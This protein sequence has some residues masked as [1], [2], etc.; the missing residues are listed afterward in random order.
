MQTTLLGLAIAIILA[1]LAALIGPYFVDW[2]QF[3]PQFEAEASRLVGAPVHVRDSLDARLLPTPTLRLRTVTIGVPSDPARLRADRLDVEF[4]LGSLMR[5]EWRAAELALDGLVVDLALDANGRLQ[6]PGGRSAPD[7]G[8]LSVDR[9]RLNGRLALHDAV[10]RDILALD[11][12]NF[13]GDVRVATAAAR[14]DGEFRLGDARYPYRLVTGRAA[15]GAGTRVHVTV[16]PGTRPI[17]F[18]LDGVL[19]F[20]ALV[21]RFDGSASLSRAITLRAGSEH[22][23]GVSMP[24]KLSGKLKADPRAIKLEQL[25]ALYGTEEAGLKLAGSADI[26]L[27]LSPSLRVAL[28]ARQLDADRLL[29][30]ET[31][32]SEPTRL[33]PGL[34][35]FIAATPVPPLPARISLAA[36]GV[37]LGGK[38]AQNLAVD[39]HSDADAWVLDRFEGRLPGAAQVTLAGR[40][41]PRP[42]PHFAGSL[43]VEAAEPDQLWAWMRGSGDAPPRLQKPLRITGLLSA[44][45]ERVALDD[46]DANI[47]GAA[48]TGRFAVSNPASP[49]HPDALRLE[50]AISGEKL[51]LDG[52]LALGRGIAGPRDNWP[53]EADLALDLRH[54]ILAGQDLAPFVVRL[55]YGAGAVTLTK[56]TLGAAGGVNVDGHGSID[57]A[58]NSGGLDI[59]AAA[60]NLQALGR[61][62]A[63]LAPAAAAARL[64]ALPAALDGAA[65]L[66]VVVKLDKGSE[67]DRA[68]LSATADID[69]PHLKAAL[70]GA[71]APPA[72]TLRDPDL[73]AL[74]QGKFTVD[75]SFNSD[76]GPLLL[77]LLTVDRIVAAGEGAAQATVSAVGSVGA[78][79]VVKLGVRGVNLDADVDGTLAIA[80]IADALGRGGA[81]VDKPDDASATTKLALAAR[82]LDLGP[83]LDA[84]AGRIPPI[85]LQT[86]IALSPRQVKLDD[87]DA[88]VAGAR[89]RGHITVDRGAS[90]EFHG[91]F[92]MDRLD[93]ATAAGLATGA[94]GRGLDDPLGALPCAGVSGTV[95]L[96]TPR[97]ILPGGLEIKGM[98][99]RLHC[100]GAAVS[101]EGKGT[102]A[103]GEA[104]T[105]L[106]VQGGSDGVVAVDAQ[107]R[108]TGVDGTALKWR[109]L[110]AP[111]GATSMQLTLTGRGRTSGVLAGALSGGGTWSVDQAKIDGLN[112]AMFDAVVTASDAGKIAGDVALREL[113]TSTLRSAPLMVKDIQVPF[114]V[115]D[116]GLRV[117][118][119][120]LDG[121][122][123]RLAVSGGYDMTADQF[124]LRADVTSTRLGSGADRPAIEISAHGPPD[125]FNRTVDVALLSSWLA[126]R[127]IDRETRRL[128]S[129]ERGDR[130]DLGPTPPVP[131]RVSPPPAPQAPPA[132]A[133]TPPSVDAPVTEVPRRPAPKPRPAPAT[134]AP[135]AVPPP[136]QVSAGPSDS[137]PPLPPPIDIR[138]APGTPRP[139][140]SRVPQP[141]PPVPPASIPN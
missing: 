75:G 104:S 138:P 36:D 119:T 93:L 81:D 87:I 84:P 113:V 95:E 5:G 53:D 57:R 19:A 70:H 94:F 64:T 45:P 59:N 80:S 24:W 114:S 73:G 26:A 117:A 101:L 107:A 98:K 12:L 41:M 9:L 115:R 134:T 83:L 102:L 37:T 79:L 58:A 17:G 16:D 71:I 62:A 60:P 34:R 141:A 67:P 11:D 28:A 139:R 6:W 23:P 120:T 111:A 96:Q 32:A 97:G 91:E 106:A 56:L 122:G 105:Q 2:N 3:R 130:V 22:V 4:S 131:P 86:R 88:T 90:P 50:A 43:T 82:K 46:V 92:G 74:G 55:A 132:P 100:D 72:E 116:G 13:V 31:A 39:I 1:L 49:K 112:P 51:D 126:V 129:L 135:Q 65:K 133:A 76:R 127:N 121:D 48:V 78:P 110:A 109:N 42:A 89:A 61:L 52:L 137:A 35:N 118:Q 33:L 30:R 29:A 103:G 38:P 21:P 54:G 123:A 47:D 124:D 66:H 140:P 68:G 125:R 10:N 40:L 14:G 25:E 8:T 63:P 108:L 85:A 69:S 99:G 7:F 128:E 15:D 44:T 20:D 27:G 77:G 18:D 136:P